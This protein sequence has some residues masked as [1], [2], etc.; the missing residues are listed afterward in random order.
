MTWLLLGGGV[1]LAVL[2]AL[3]CAALVEVFRQLAEIRRSL[4]L[5]DLPI[6]IALKT[7]G[8]RVTDIGLPPELAEAPAAIVVF[9]SPKCASCLAIAEAFRGGAP[10]SVWFVLPTP[11]YPD[12]LVEALSQSGERVILD[13]SDRIV[14]AIDLRVTPAVL[15]MSFGEIRRSQAVSSP[16][17]VMSLIPTVFPADGGGAS[18]VGSAIANAVA[19]KGGDAT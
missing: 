13:E 9:L 4:N 3:C 18:R 5:E 1:V 8:L 2:V 17:Q 11:P 19:L 15:T 7:G 16:R 14:D 6:P 10:A 12:Q